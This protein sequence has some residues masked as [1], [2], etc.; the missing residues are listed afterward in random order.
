MCVYLFCLA[1]L[2]AKFS[3]CFDRKKSQV[4]FSVGENVGVVR[5]EADRNKQFV[6]WLAAEKKWTP[7]K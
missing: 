5:L 4:V 3:E 1:E 7:V 6:V 2:S